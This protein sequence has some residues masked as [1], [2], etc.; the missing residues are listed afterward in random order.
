VKRRTRTL[1]FLAAAAAALGALVLAELRRERGLAPEPLTAIDPTAVRSLV[2]AC[3]GCTT[4]RFEK[5]DG[6]WQ[7]RAPRTGAADAAVVDRLA[8]I[9]RAPV[10]LRHAAG[11]LDPARVGLDPP[12]ATL[13]LDGTLLKFGTTDA[14]NGD[15]YVEAGGS[16][17]LVPDRFSALLFAAPENGLAAPPAAPKE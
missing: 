11:E 2:V 1:A 10:R 12:Q 9:A 3:N 7:M 15:R 16:I 5:E 4:R 14:I 13:Q 8:A 17:A 6:R